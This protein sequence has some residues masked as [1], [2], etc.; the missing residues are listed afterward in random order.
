MFRIIFTVFFAYFIYKIAR[1]LIDP[2]FESSERINPMQPPPRNKERV[3]NVSASPK[4]GEYIDY[5]EIK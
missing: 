3:S 5:E 4:A 2:L 1:V